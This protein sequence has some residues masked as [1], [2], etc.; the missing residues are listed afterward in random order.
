M[1]SVTIASIVAIATGMAGTILGLRSEW[2]ALV[3]RRQESTEKR[4]AALHALSLVVHAGFNLPINR[5]DNL[6]F[7]DISS[8]RDELRSLAQRATDAVLPVGYAWPDAVLQLRNVALVSEQ[9]TN[10]NK[11]SPPDLL[12]TG[13]TSLYGQLYLL[14]VR[15]LERTDFGGGADDSWA[16]TATSVLRKKFDAFSRA[17]DAHGL[18]S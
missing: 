14:A 18:S 15:I 1:T 5:A 13:V 3:T 11:H 17:A 9:L 10:V 4:L 6:K 2:R 7:E 16:N 12:L 8:V